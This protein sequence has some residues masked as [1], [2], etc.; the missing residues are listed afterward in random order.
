MS[1]QKL[2]SAYHPHDPVTLDTGRLSLTKQSFQKETDI[3]N[4]MK[5]FAK[6]GLLTHTM[7]V[8]G[9]YGDF[10]SAP[11]YHEAMNQILAAQEAFASLPSKIRNRFNNNPED[12][13][14]FTQDPGNTDELIKLGLV[15]PPAPKPGAIIETK[16]LPAEDTPQPPTPPLDP[17]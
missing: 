2:R 14:S 6:T 12:F 3:N 9:R 7:S 11:E 4:I 5:Q 17:S 1:D 10:V 8:Q 15:E 16:P 13:L